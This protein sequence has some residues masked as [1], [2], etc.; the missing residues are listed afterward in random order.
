MCNIDVDIYDA[1]KSSLEKV[2]PL[3]V[4]NGII[5]CEDFGHTPALGG[6]NLSVREFLETDEGKKYIP[7]YME[8]GQMFLIKRKI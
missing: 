4:E 1:V 3:I 6:A 5:I 8:S 2:S 7:I